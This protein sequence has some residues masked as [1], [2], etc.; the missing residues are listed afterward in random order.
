MRTHQLRLLAAL[1]VLAL[2]CLTLVAVT[3]PPAAACVSSA[4]CPGDD[5]DNGDDQKVT[6]DDTVEEHLNEN[7]AHCAVYANGGGMGMFCYTAGGPARGS[8]RERFGDM[9]FQ[10]CR[11]S[12]IPPS[13]EPPF[14]AN[15]ADGRYMMMTC[16]ENID[17]DTYSGGNHRSIDISLVFVPNGTDTADRDNPLNRFLWNQFDSDTQMPV[18]FMRARPNVT[19]LVG[20]PTFFTFRWID[21]ATNKVVAE[22]PYT[23]RANGGPY[24]E[25]ESDG[26]VMKA[27]ATQITID[28]RQRGIKSATCDPETPYIEGASPKNQ[29]ANAC[30][31]IF[32]RSSAS[33]RK[34]A[35]KPI[36]DDIKDAFYADVTVTWDVT[37]GTD[38]G[39]MHTLGDG[40][41]MRMRQV[42]PVQ[43]VQAP[44][45]PPAVIY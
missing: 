28:P 11:Y 32:D 1:P 30:K 20:I 8:L 44:N 5:S 40:F 4:S 33:A 6:S 18:P 43:E 2:M 26:V 29:P 41:T 25:I 19:P 22:G 12:E 27:R 31:I 9:K 24:R 42:L 45:Q 35:T 13:I 7:G 21:P 14:N 39:A 38:A 34:Y 3:A 15:P 17:F 37:Y 23:D 36:P 10:R 16:L